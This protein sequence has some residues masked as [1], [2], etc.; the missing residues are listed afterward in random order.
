MSHD[1]VKLWSN[2]RNKLITFET[3][4]WLNKD[5]DIDISLQESINKKNDNPE[6]LRLISLDHIN[7]YNTYTH[8]YTDGAKAENLVA[9]AYT[10]PTLNLNKQFR[11]CY[12]SSKYA[13]E[14]TAIKEI[15]SRTSENETQDLKNFV[16]FSDSLSVLTFFKHSFSESRPN[17]LQETI[18]TFKVHFIWIP[19]HVNILGNERAD[20]LAKISLNIPS[21]N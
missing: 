18:Q 7:R 15:L 1:D 6:L 12:S 8:I 14:L 4:L 3:P 19:S 9:A 2:K 5:V 10:I 20:A 13:A 16:I 11:L 17:L 21:I